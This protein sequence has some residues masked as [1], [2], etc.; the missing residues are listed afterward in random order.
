MHG[1]TKSA[2]DRYGPGGYKHWDVVDLGWKYNMSDIQAALGIAQLSDMSTW[3]G[4]R[5]MLDGVYRNFVDRDLVSVLEPKDERISSARHLFVVRVRNRDTVMDKVQRQGIGVGVHFR[6]VYKLKYYQDKYRISGKD[7]PVSEKASN[8]VI[9]LPLYPAME[10]KDVYRV[11]DVLHRTVRE[12]K[13]N[14]C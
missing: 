11:L 6:A 5:I 1:V 2:W 13:H 14:L 8:E 9:S 7:L 4:K 10:V 3:L 12:I